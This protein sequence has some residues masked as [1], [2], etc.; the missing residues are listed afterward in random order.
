MFE[1]DLQDLQWKLQAVKEMG[2][3]TSHACQSVTR[4]LS[5]RLIP[6]TGR[7]AVIGWSLQV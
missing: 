1:N 6:S 3:A 5:K 2:G 4:S 7:Y